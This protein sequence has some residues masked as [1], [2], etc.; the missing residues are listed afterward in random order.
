MWHALCPKL[1]TCDEGELDGGLGGQGLQD[2]AQVVVGNYVEV[3]RADAA[4]GEGRCAG[5]GMWVTAGR[6]GH[7]QPGPRSIHITEENVQSL[8]PS[9][10]LGPLPPQP[11]AQPTACSATHA[12]GR[13][14]GRS[15]P[16]GGGGGAEF[17]GGKGGR[18]RGVW[19][20][21]GQAGRGGRHSCQA[22]GVLLPPCGTSLPVATPVLPPCTPRP[23]RRPPVEPRPAR[24]R[25]SPSSC[26][27]TFQARA[28][29]KQQGTQEG[30]VK[31]PGGLQARLLVQQ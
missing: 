8:T 18:L 6:A 27:H 14:G 19:A 22:Q 12:G 29:G 28:A 1:R 10:P 25:A 17:H 11:K 31:A 15:V 26:V 13:R 24:P 16:M 4:A 3:R 30:S 20:V 21:G 7:D 5:A 9:T 23:E 2:G